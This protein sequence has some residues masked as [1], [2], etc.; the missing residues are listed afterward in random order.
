MLISSLKRSFDWK[1]Y[2]WF[3]VLFLCWVVSIIIVNPFHEFPLNDDWSYSK[4]VLNLYENGVLR[5]EDWLGMP[6]ITQVFWGSLF[7]IPCGFSFTALRISTLV[8]GFIGLVA[9]YHLVREF[10]ENRKVSLMFTLIIAANPLFFSLSNS[11]MT[12][13]PFYAFYILSLLFYLKNLKSKKVIYL[14]AGVLMSIL[15]TLIRQTGILLPASVFIYS[16]LIYYKSDKK[17]IFKYLISLLIVTGS[18]LL[19]NQWLDLT[20][21]TPE[22]YRTLPEIQ[23]W[24]FFIRE[25]AWLIFTRSGMILNEMGFWFFP[26]LIIA[27]KYNIAGIKK[28]VKWVAIISVI[29]LIPLIRTNAMV[30][31]GNIFNILELGP[32]L[33]ADTY[34]FEE[35]RDIFSYSSVTLFFRLVSMLGGILLI[36]NLLSNI[37]QVFSRNKSYGQSQKM[38]FTLSFI[39]M[40]SYFGVYVLS[41]TYFDRYMISFFGIFIFLLFPFSIKSLKLSRRSVVL[42]YTF[43]IILWLFSM[44]ATRDYFSWN[45]ARWEA[46]GSLM[47]EGISPSKIDGGHEFNGWYGADLNI[48]GQWDTGSYDYFITFGKL[49]GFE[50]VDSYQYK[51]LLHPGEHRLFVCKKGNGAGIQ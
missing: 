43:I 12:D 24:G 29:F 40:L 26:F 14:I 33:L 20:G 27:T 38:L 45:E 8:L 39:I 37:L 48:F 2:G 19:Y 28:N 17:L 18:L 1:E 25:K 44:A 46:A 36:V 3:P 30:P 42:T 35:N 41:Y 6:L 32:L 21:R 51:L 23:N 16:L 49:D 13:V 5:F 11:F 47:K 34:I 9:T 22:F 31:S 50:C 15:A 10:S 7:C 4:T